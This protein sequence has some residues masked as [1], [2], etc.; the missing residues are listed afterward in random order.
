MPVWQYLTVIGV[1]FPPEISISL[2]VGALARLLTND[3]EVFCSQY[4]HDRERNW[5]FLIPKCAIAD[6]R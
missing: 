3:L 5:L 4:L 1:I 6:P 2:F